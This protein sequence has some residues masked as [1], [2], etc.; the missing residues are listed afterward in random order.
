MNKFWY[1][2]FGIAAGIW[3]VTIIFDPIQ[4]SSRYNYTWDFTEVKWPLGGF[5]IILGSYILISSL[6]KK[7]SDFEEIVLMCPKCVVPYS[8]KA[9]RNNLCP[10]CGTQLENLDGFYERH[11][12]L[13]GK[14]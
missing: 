13:G 11:P 14:P 1:I 4:H 7:S 6:R 8:K 10:T 3:G 5:L 9:L 2:L 12:E